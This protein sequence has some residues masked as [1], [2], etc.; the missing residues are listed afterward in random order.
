MA[1]INN[2]KLHFDRKNFRFLFQSV[3]QDPGSFIGGLVNV[4]FIHIR[5]VKHQLFNMT[6]QILTINNY[7]T[8]T[9]KGNYLTEG[10]KI[11]VVKGTRG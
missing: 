8:G 10:S 5:F 4:D 1:D 2:I 6:D 3:Y 7:F 9:V 11:K